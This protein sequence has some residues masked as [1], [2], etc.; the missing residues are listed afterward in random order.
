MGRYTEETG[1][2]IKRRV[3]VREENE[4]GGGWKRVVG[5]ERIEKGEGGVETA[6][7]R[8]AGQGS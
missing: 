1:T 8:L 5:G 7:E 6:R 3:V 2:A 4:A